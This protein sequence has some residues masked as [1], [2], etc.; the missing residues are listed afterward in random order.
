[1]ARCELGNPAAG[2]LVEAPGG[3]IV[4]ELLAAL[5]AK[6]QREGLQ[7]PVIEQSGATRGVDQHRTFLVHVDAARRTGVGAGMSGE[8]AVV[9]QAQHPGRAL[10]THENP[11]R[12]VLE[13]PAPALVA[14]VV[15]AD[16]GLRGAVAHGLTLD[17]PAPAAIQPEPA[18][19]RRHVRPLRHRAQHGVIH[20][21]T[22]AACRTPRRRTASAV[23]PTRAKRHE[24]S[25]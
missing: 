16:E 23:A 3:L 4:V 14:G 11:L 7:I 13:E 2:E 10:Q 12:A 6:A 24:G 25:L 20:G 17:Q 18:E 1:M 15:A 9:F 5:A 19:H 21:V 22:L 8:A